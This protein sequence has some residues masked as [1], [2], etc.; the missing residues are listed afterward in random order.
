[1]MVAPHRKGRLRPRETSSRRVSNEVLV[2]DPVPHGSLTQ[3]TNLS[4]NDAHGYLLDTFHGT[5][6]TIRTSGSLLKI[7]CRYNAT[8]LQEKVGTKKRYRPSS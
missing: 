8:F 6:G 2:K 5:P 1:M 3:T 7:R 4:H